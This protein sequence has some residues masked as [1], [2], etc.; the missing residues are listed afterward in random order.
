[1][2]TVKT[3]GKGANHMKM[4]AAAV[5]FATVASP[6]AANAAVIRTPTISVPHVNV[7][8]NAT[9]IGNVGSTVSVRTKV[10]DASSP[11]LYKMCATGKHFK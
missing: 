11:T 8:V 4:I 3:I 1:M 7:A 2:S 10:T 6:L 5:L 9:H